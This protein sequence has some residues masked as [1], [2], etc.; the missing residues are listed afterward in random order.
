MQ[1]DKVGQ[2]PVSALTEFANEEVMPGMP[3]TERE[4]K[5][6][7]QREGVQSKRMLEIAIHLRESHRRGA[8]E[9]GF[10]RQRRFQQTGEP[11]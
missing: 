5:Y 11:C 8:S 1:A 3:T 6:G 4:H 9:P 10:E 7:R 2:D